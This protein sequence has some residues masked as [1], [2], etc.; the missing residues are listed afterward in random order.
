[1]TDLNK[2][3][4]NKA[5]KVH[6]E[7][8]SYD[9]ID[10]LNVKTKI[11]IT[12]PKHG[13]FLQNPSTHLRGSLCPKCAKEK[14]VK[15]ISKTTEWFIKKSMKIHN[16]FYIYDKTL[17]VKTSG[18]V[19]IT[20]PEHGDFTQVAQSHL[21]GR[22][23]PECGR[24]KHTTDMK[25]FII[26]AMEL[27]GDR[28]N[29]DKSTYYNCKTDM[30]ITCSAH[31]DFNQKPS[32]HLSGQGCPK[33]GLSKRAASRT[34]DIYTFTT[35]ANQIHDNRYS[36]TKTEYVNNH[37]KIIIDCPVHGEF[38]QRPIEHLYHK[39]GCPDC[40]RERSGM[41]RR[42]T[43]TAFETKANIIHNSKYKYFEYINY[44]TKVKIECPSHGIFYQTPDDHLAGKGCAKCAYVNGTSK[45]QRDIFEFIES[46]GIHVD[47]NI[48]GI[49]G[50]KHLDI[51]ISSHKLAIEYNGLYWHNDQMPNRTSPDYHYDK[52]LKAVKA[53]YDLIMI[54]ED[55]WSKK[56]EI[57]KKIIKRRLNV[58][59][60]PINEQFNVEN[61][62][63]ERANDFLINEDINDILAEYT[64]SYGIFCDGVLIAVTTFNKTLLD[65][66]W[67]MVRSVDVT[68]TS[69]SHLSKILEIFITTYEPN[70][71]SVITDNRWSNG[72]EYEMVGFKFVKDIP[73]DFD[74]IRASNRFNQ[75]SF[76]GKT[77]EEIQNEG[78][79][80]MWDCGKKE[81]VL[82]NSQY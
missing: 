66:N 63:T 39:Q 48:N 60:L 14:F 23:C 82:S 81:W 70:E 30:I 52:H 9:K 46:L 15:T 8:Y 80:R 42:L 73:I 37:E 61:I 49:I 65:D 64:V 10:Y 44:D 25:I 28:Y 62:S 72:T 51:V 22:G 6:N 36:Y 18:K 54:N 5:L 38:K 2:I 21:N 31:G 20:C 43:F 26:N 74:Y 16:S 29:Y 59:D 27:H 50:R 19:I 11:I 45:A 34:K 1:M 35:Q 71:I 79:L 3:F 77:L 47:D 13:D 7:F 55:E 12:C 57:V 53:G 24:L 58:Y 56:S 69:Y 68:E 76:V 32:K 40:G 4:K 78:Y 67:E 33:C 75:N 41:S 17:Y